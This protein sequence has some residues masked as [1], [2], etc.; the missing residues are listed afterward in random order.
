MELVAVVGGTI[1]S[2]YLI[3][4]QKK[5]RQDPLRLSEKVSVKVNSETS[6]DSFVAHL[7]APHFIGNMNG[8]IGKELLDLRALWSAEKATFGLIWKGFS[9]RQ[10]VNLLK[11]L[12]DELKFAIEIYSDT[13]ELLRILCPKISEEY[14]FA[15]SEVHQHSSEQVTE[16][17]DKETP[18]IVKYILAVQDKTDIKYYCPPILLMGV[19]R[20]EK[21]L[22][23]NGV[24]VPVADP[25]LSEHAELF[26]R[27]LQQ[28]CAIKFAK[29]VLLRYKADTKKSTLFRII[30]KLGPL[31]LFGLL[32]ALVAYLLDKYHFFSTFMFSYKSPF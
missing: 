24:A 3:F 27:S 4:K 13:N 15:K 5:A 14:F 16:D 28:I 32:A 19:D 26:L 20:L 1:L 23:P 18:T 8:S 30:K 10:K 25:A 2:T 6:F 22:D 12:I 29:Q 11:T 17:S 9:E 7:P 31:V 21:D